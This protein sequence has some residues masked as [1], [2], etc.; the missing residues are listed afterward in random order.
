MAGLPAPLPV[1]AWEEAAARAAAFLATEPAQLIVQLELATAFAD[2]NHSHD[3]DAASTTSTTT[4]RSATRSPGPSDIR[5][6]L[7]PG[8]GEALAALSMADAQALAL[9]WLPPPTRAAALPSDLC[10]FVA[11]ACAARLFRPHAATEQ[12]VR[13][14]SPHTTVQDP[15]AAH[16]AQLPAFD[17]GPLPAL[18][19]LLRTGLKPKKV[20]EV[21]RLAA[22]TAAVARQAGC[23]RAV[24]MGSGKGYLGKVCPGVDHMHS[25]IP[26]VSIT[27]PPT[28]SPSR[29]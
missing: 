27:P 2:D 8:W 5:A 29:S 4:P 10:G 12:Q 26:Q 6:R 18:P 21:Q 16:A 24:D 25:S 7:P 1:A 19:P 17:V 14:H 20:H 22:L 28:S 23:R 13:Q 3:H 11:A 15:A 9:G